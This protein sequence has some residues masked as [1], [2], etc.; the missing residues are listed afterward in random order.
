MKK[1]LQ[2]ICIYQKIVVLLH[3]HLKRNGTNQIKNQINYHY[4]KDQFTKD[5]SPRG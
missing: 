2:K 5:C 1:S 3:R 4:G